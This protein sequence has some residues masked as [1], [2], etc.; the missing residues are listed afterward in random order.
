MKICGNELCDGYRN[1]YEVGTQW[2]DSV[3]LNRV[4]VLLGARLVTIEQLFRYLDATDE[5]YSDDYRDRSERHPD[6][7]FGLG[8]TIGFNQ[9]C[10]DAV[11]E[12]SKRSA[13]RR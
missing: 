3:R 12:R 5:W 9:A 10:E 4:R 6:E 11:K 1:G 2:A 13:A 7:P 8:F